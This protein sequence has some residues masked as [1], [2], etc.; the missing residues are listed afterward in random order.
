MKDLL[1]VLIPTSPIPSH[2]STHILDKTIANVRKYTDARIIIMFD[3]VHESL[4][5]RKEDYFEYKRKVMDD[6]GRGVHNDCIYVEASSHAHQ[7]KLTDYILRR[8]R[9]KVTT[10][11]IMFVEHDTFPSG[12]IPFR[13]LCEIVQS[14]PDVN[15]IRFNIFDR[16]LD[17]HKYL[18]LGQREI[19]GHKFEHTIQW[20]QRPHIAKTDWYTKILNSYFAPQDKTMIE[21]VM[22]GVVQVSYDKFKK[23]VFGLYIYTPDGNQLRSLHSDGRGTDEKIIIG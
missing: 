19:N 16:I 18:M 4:A 11:L 12:D 21:D 14:N 7:A 2:P 20:S 23:D 17:E 10:P 15:Y 3:G 1:T 13:E 22:H 8:S 6:I 5:H 9:N